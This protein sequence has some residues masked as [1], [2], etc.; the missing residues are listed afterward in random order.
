MRLDPGTNYTLGESRASASHAAGNHEGAAVDHSGGSSVS[1]FFSVSGVGTGGTLD[2]KVQYSS[3]NSTWTDDDGTTGNDTAI[4]QIDAA[5]TAQLNVP[6]PR[7]RYSRV[8]CTVATDAVVFGA[9][10][11]LGPKRSATP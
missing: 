9:F 4:T 3:D 6:N 5:G 2:A 10:S 8:Y 7:A 1:F 11:V